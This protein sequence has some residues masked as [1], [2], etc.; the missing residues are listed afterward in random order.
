MVLRVVYREQLRLADRSHCIG[1]CLVNAAIL[2]LSERKVVAVNVSGVAYLMSRCSDTTVERRRTPGIGQVEIAEL[3]DGL[4]HVAVLGSERRRA[5]AQG[6]CAE[7]RGD[8]QTGLLGGSDQSFHDGLLVPGKSFRVSGGFF[9]RFGAA[10]TQATV[11]RAAAG[12]LIA[13]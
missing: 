2:S 7:E 5:T 4:R 11:L 13:V 9:R 8:D 1:N 12:V 10:G 6:K 3:H